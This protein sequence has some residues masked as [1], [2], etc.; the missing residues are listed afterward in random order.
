MSSAKK[1]YVAFD[2]YKR[3]DR[4][5]RNIRGKYYEEM[6]NGNKQSLDKEKML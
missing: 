2:G 5:Y 3:L 6:G 4:A 1:T